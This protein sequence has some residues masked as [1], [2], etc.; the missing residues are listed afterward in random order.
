M[1]RE[2][3]K[4]ERIV[5]R[6]LSGDLLVREARDFERYCLEH[7]EVLDT[8]AIPARI[9]AQLSTKTF[10]SNDT[11]VFS[12]MPSSVTRIAAATGLRTV[13]AEEDKTDEEDDDQPAG[14]NSKFSKPLLAFLI[15]ALGG[16]GALLWQNQAQQKQI[17]TL[18]VTA[19]ALKL[20]APGA[21]QTLKIIPSDVRPTDPQASVSLNQAQL[22]DI[23]IDVSGLPYSNFALTIDKTDEA[24]LIQIRRIDADTNKELR[25]SLNSSAFGAGE[26]EIKLQGYN[27]KGETSDAGWVVLALR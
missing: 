21:M 20:Q 10:N 2:Q 1:D 14:D 22:L 16:V 23:H 8:L 11:S 7:P 3:I 5:E 24:R 4:S 12:A 19:K 17:K 15:I 9:K 13:A 26:Y 18:S 6:Y 27:Y 25:F